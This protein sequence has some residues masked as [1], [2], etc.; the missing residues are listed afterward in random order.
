MLDSVLESLMMLVLSDRAVWGESGSHSIITPF[1]ASTPSTF[2]KIHVYGQVVGLYIAKLQRWPS[3]L[4]PLMMAFFFH[5]ASS[6]HG[7]LDP[8]YLPLEMVSNFNS[9]AGK[10]LWPFFQLIK[11]SG[12]GDLVDIP[13]EDPLFHRVDKLFL[14]LYGKNVSSDLFIRHQVVN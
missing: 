14:S 2:D 5:H 1:T 4:S 10:L 13:K 8:S 7:N 6:A 3:G 11:R 12:D 9:T